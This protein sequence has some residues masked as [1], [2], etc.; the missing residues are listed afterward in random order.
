MNMN[1]E[2]NTELHFVLNRAQSYDC[3][4]NSNGSNAAHY[5]KGDIS[6]DIV[7]GLQGTNEPTL[8][9]RT[10]LNTNIPTHSILGTIF[11]HMAN[12]FGHF[13]LLTKQQTL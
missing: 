11:P 7:P 1:E 2:V 10:P 12:S 9:Q 8:Q 6:C 3:P 13:I 4:L 5:I